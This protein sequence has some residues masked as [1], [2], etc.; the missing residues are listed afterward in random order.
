MEKQPYR[1]FTEGHEKE[2][3]IDIIMSD[4][5]LRSAAQTFLAAQSIKRAFNTALRVAALVDAG[6]IVLSVVLATTFGSPVRTLTPHC[7][8]NETH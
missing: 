1:P 8:Q 7:P 3:Y 4:P 5:I 6:I 2:Y